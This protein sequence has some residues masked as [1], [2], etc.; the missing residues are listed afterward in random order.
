[1]NADDWLALAAVTIQILCAT[2]TMFLF[3][4][5]AFKYLGWT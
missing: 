1:M 3:W 2:F 4:L 5:C